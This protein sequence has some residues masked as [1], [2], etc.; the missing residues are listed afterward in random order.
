MFS[1]VEIHAFTG[2]DMCHQCFAWDTLQQSVVMVPPSAENPV[3]GV[4]LLEY[5]YQFLL[6]STGKVYRPTNQPVSKG[7]FNLL[8]EGD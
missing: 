8:L 2:Q 6:V 1:T 3:T 4:N 5:L 7:G